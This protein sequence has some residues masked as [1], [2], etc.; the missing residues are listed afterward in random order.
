MGFTSSFWITYDG[1]KTKKNK[2]SNFLTKDLTISNE[3]SKWRTE[4]LINEHLVGR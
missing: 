2:R 4:I 1:G 3:N